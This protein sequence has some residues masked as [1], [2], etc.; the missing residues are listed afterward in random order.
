MLCDTQELHSWALSLSTTLSFYEIMETG[1][2]ITYETIT[3]AHRTTVNLLDGRTYSERQLLSVKITAC[4][5][6]VTIIFISLGTAKTIQS[7]RNSQLVVTWLDCVVGVI[8]GTM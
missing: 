6:L 3:Y 1:I 2:D 7:L 4:R 8:F 5:L